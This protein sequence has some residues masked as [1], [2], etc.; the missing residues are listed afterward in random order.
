MYSSK[1]G[2]ATLD[3]IIE[4]GDAI[5]VAIFNPEELESGIARLT[6]SGFI[7]E[8]EG[9]FL[10]TAKAQLQTKPG[11]LRSMQSELKD[12]ETLLGCPPF[13]AIQPSPDNLRYPGCSLEAYEQ[14]VET[15]RQRGLRLR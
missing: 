4:A 2:A 12:L 5:N 10:P 7:T 6:H 9:G 11:Q 8:R 14:A 13:N 3:R 15:Y 1:N